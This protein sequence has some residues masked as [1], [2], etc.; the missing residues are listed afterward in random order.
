MS[1]FSAVDL[2]QMPFPETVRAPNFETELASLKADFIQRMPEA[3]EVL[4]LESEPLTMAF[5]LFAEKL[6]SLLSLIND[7]TRKNTLPH[8]FGTS[9]DNFAA[10]T[11]VVRA[12]VQ[13]AD[14][15]AN[16][17]VLEI[18]E[19]DDRLRRRVQLS[20]E[21]FTTCG[22]VGSYIFW[23]LAASSDVKNIS[24]KR[25]EQGDVQITVLSEQDQGA[26]SADL[27]QAVEAEITPR[28]PLTDNPI[29]Q[30][31]VI[32]AYVI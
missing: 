9:L 15:N 8:A 28:R 1:R 11:G 26:A 4:N 14:P 19:D 2:T 12:V 23:A 25:L 3:A 24:V 18:L 29:F 6:V 30:S 7:D 32:Q 10:N 16:P 17:P 21:G 5:E 13:D 20:L 22:T 31:A 27:L